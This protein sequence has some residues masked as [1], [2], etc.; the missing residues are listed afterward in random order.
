MLLWLWHRP[1]ALALIRSLG[2]EPPYVTGVA[3]KRQKKAKKKQKQIQKNLISWIWSLK[4]QVAISTP[5]TQIVVLNTK[6][7]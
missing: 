2:W 5:S 3:L 6:V 4:N 7:L 1:A